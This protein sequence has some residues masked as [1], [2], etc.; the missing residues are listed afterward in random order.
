MYVS[1]RSTLLVHVPLVLLT[2]IACTQ[3]REPRT[4]AAGETR[5]AAAGDTGSAA[6]GQT[7]TAAAVFDDWKGDA[8]GVRHHIR[9]SDLSAPTAVGDPE[10][11][12]ASNAKVVPPPQGAAPRVPA[13][14]EVQVCARGCKHPRTVRAAPNGDIFLSESGTGRVLVYGP[15]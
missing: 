15:S 1:M 8:P 5:S 7:R 10:A 4:G 6:A 3:I 2:A 14:C 9:P 11:S 13:G 12:I